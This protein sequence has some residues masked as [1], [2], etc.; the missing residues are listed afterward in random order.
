MTTKTPVK[1]RSRGLEEVD[2]R[3]AQEILASGYELV[4]LWDEN[5][6]TWLICRK[7]DGQLFLGYPWEPSIPFVKLLGQGT[8]QAVGALLN[9]ANLVNTII[10]IPM[11]ILQGAKNQVQY[12][13][14]WDF[15]DAGSLGGF[16][17]MTGAAGVPRQEVTTDGRVKKYL[18]ESLVWH[19]AI[20]ML[21]ALAWLHEG[22]REEVC[23]VW[24]GDEPTMETRGWRAETEQDGSMG[25]D[26]MPILHRD[27]R[28]DNIFFQH[29]RGSETYGYCKLGNFSKAF[30]SG[31]V[32]NTSGGQVVCSA[33]DK[34][35]L[36]KLRQ[37]MSVQDIYTVKKVSSW[38]FVV[39]PAFKPYGVPGDNQ[40]DISRRTNDLILEAR[41]CTTSEKCYTR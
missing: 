15:C 2:T 37:H 26:W 25:E 9:H 22:Y 27:I 19:V 40:S 38:L 18:P 30:V 6:N 29:P 28:A 39:P 10:N 5:S 17:K 21:R 35:P 34:V 41:S 23:I 14:V 16:M 20:S 1:S 33:N 36:R 32:H 3:T 31:H 8:G 24:E 13:S 7:K 4:K 11:N 12:F